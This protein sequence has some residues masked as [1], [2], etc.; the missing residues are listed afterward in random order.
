MK[1]IKLIKHLDFNI[2]IDGN[3]LFYKK[4]NIL[5]EIILSKKKTYSLSLYVPI[6]V[7]YKGVIILEKKYIFI[8][9][10]PLLT[11]KGNFI[12]NGNTRVLIVFKN[13]KD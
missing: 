11:E 13:I 6:S 5:P 1:K 12:I 3:K 7:K 10:I 2:K 9:K 4:S 8:G